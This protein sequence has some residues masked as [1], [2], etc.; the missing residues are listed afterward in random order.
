M[1]SI[2]PGLLPSLRMDAGRY[3]EL[4]VLERLRDHLPSGFEVFHNIALHTIRGGRDCYGEIDVAVLSPA[5]CLLLIEVKAGPVVLREGGIFKLYGDGEC[6]VARQGRLQR[7]AMQNRLQDAGLKTELLSCL[8]LPDYTLGDSQVVSIPRDRIID[9]S[10]Y[11]S[12]VATV[13]QWLQG[14]PGRVDREALRRLLLNQFRVTPDL[15]TM[16]EQLQGTVRRLSDGLATWVPRID[17]PS[18][19]FRI[20]AT[21][22]S[23]KTQ[24][25]LQLLDT[26]AAEGNNASYVCFNRSL[27][28]HVRRL[29]SPKVQ[30]VNYHELCVE[31]YRRHHGDPDFTPE[32]YHRMANAYFEASVGFTPSLDL[33]IVDEAQD[34]DAS[35]VQTLCQRLKPGGRLYVLED[36]A[37][38]LYQQPEFE[39][40]DAVTIRCSDNFR[41]PRV[42]CDVINALALVSPPIRSLNPWSG[43]VPGIHA[44]GSD[45]ELLAATG[46]AVSALLAR[47]F[48][49]GDIVIVSGRGRERSA[50][51][52]RVMIGDWRTRRFTGEYDRNGEPRWSGGELLVESVYRY[53]GQSAPAVV[54]AE[55]DFAELD[56][57][58]R[59][60]LFVA[61]TRAQMAAELVLSTRAE[62]CLTAAL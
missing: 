13:Q 61:L 55:F 47:G 3:R 30:V 18:G 24:L 48:A 62:R 22:G 2:S 1:A 31:H 59:R 56:D 52:N 7:A 15:A 14:V 6:D 33:L 58:V 39:L 27:A 35:W 51:L 29:A 10:G 50:L 26:A 45:E 5:G 12:M 42:I 36:E 4:E 57:V 53:K 9:A 23:G 46:A 40:D 54:V 32:S 19:I 43:E 38:R 41:S 21:A 20:Q 17:A 25:A 8:V 60:K 28:D 11:E 34:F 16:R 44:Y 49:L 37:Q